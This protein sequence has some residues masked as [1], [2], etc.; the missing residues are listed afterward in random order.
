MV[1]S[2]FPAEVMLISI[3][4]IISFDSVM[5]CA[6]RVILFC[7][8]ITYSNVCVTRQLDVN[9]YLRLKQQCNVNDSKK[10]R[11]NTKLPERGNKFCAV[12]DM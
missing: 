12:F 1:D 4:F 5:K 6:M 7:C 9:A 10:N 3:S 8:N 2:Q 11:E